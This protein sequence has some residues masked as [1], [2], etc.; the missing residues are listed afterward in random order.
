VTDQFD[1]ETGEIIPAGQALSAIDTAAL[2]TLVRVE[3]DQQIA[4]ARAYPRSIDRAV[5]NIVALATLDEETAEECCYALTRKKKR[6]NRNGTPDDEENKPIEGPSVRLAEIAAQQWGNNRSGANV[7]E[8]N[9]KEKYVAAEGFFLDLE[10]NAAT[11]M[12]V[13]RR[14]STKGGGIF[15]DDMIIVTGNA[16]CAIAKR[17][18]ILAGIP[19]GVYRPA[20]HRAREIIAGTA[21][22]LSANRAK[23]IDAFKRFGVTPDQL[24]DALCVDGEGDIKPSHIATLRAMFATLRNSEQTVEDMFGKPEPDHKVVT[25]ALADEPA[26]ESKPAAQASADHGG[27]EASAGGEGEAHPGGHAAGHQPAA[28]TDSA[29]PQANR[30]PVNEWF[31]RGSKAAADGMSRKALPP[32]LRSPERAD[33]AEA[34]FSGFDSV[35]NGGAQ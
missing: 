16:A 10:T 32:E 17:N 11:K 12:T 18:A 8:V 19:R 21:E 7:V 2:A 25:N 3:I 9:R 27:A 23:A 29:S 30:E 4:T 24:F 14:I 31:A 28:A 20:Y 5:K 35:K 6:N 13:R 26:E 33:D 1:E 15:S 34:W 22:T